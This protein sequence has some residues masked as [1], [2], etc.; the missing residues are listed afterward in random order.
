MNNEKDRL[1]YYGNWDSWIH[2]TIL[3]NKLRKPKE[4][5]AYKIK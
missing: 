4:C 1:K 2:L 5:G 3:Y